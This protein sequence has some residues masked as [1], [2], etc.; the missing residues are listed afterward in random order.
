MSLAPGMKLGPYEILSPL[1]AGGM[2]EVWKAKD[3]RLDRLVAI[4][5]LPE[6]LATHPD[7][8]ARFEREAKAVAALNHPNITALF[9]IGQEGSTAFAVMELLEGESLRSRLT[10]GPQPTRKVLDWARQIAAG[11]AAAHEKGIVH[12]DLKPDNLWITRDGRLK[13]LDFGLAKIAEAALLSSDP[14]QPTRAL[15]SGPRTQ[16]GVVLGT[17]GY[18][19][20]EQIRGQAV[21][22]RSDIFA[23]G[24][25]LFEMLAGQHPFQG[26]SAIETLNAILT[27]E[28]PT[29]DPTLEVPPA[30]ARILDHCLQ[31]DPAN[32][33]QSAGD[34]AFALETLSQS[35][36]SG[37]Y[38]PRPGTS[39]TTRTRPAGWTLGLALAGLLLGLAGL[40]GLALK[41]GL[42]EEPTHRQL[43][44]RQGTLLAA[45]FHPD[46]RNLLLTAAWDGQPLSLYRMGLDGTPATDL[47]IRHARIQAVNA[48]GEALLVLLPEP[49]WSS[50]VSDFRTSEGTLALLSPDGGAP[51]PLLK[52]VHAADFGPGGQELAVAY[53]PAE[54]PSIRVEYP[55]GMVLHEERGGEIWELRCSPD[56]TRVAVLRAPNEKD[57]HAILVLDRKGRRVEGWTD[58]CRGPVWGLAWSADGEEL[59]FHREGA[60]WAVNRK[61]RERILRREAVK[62]EVMD[63]SRS[64]ACLVA[65]SILQASTFVRR[66]GREIDLSS[67]P[68]SRMNGITSDGRQVLLNLAGGQPGVR[69][70]LRPSSGGPQVIL[71]SG[72]ALDLHPGGAWVFVNDRS[73][74]SERFLL[75]P[76]GPGTPRVVEHKGFRIWGGFF[77]ASGRNLMV[78]A[79]GEGRGQEMWR[80]P[81]EGGAWERV[82]TD[83]TGFTTFTNPDDSAIL[84]LGADHQPTLKSLTGGASRPL[85]P[86][87]APDQAIY[88]W[89]GQQ[90][91]LV[92]PDLLGRDM[93]IDLL[94]LRTG[95][96]SPWQRI[97][98]SDTSG[99]TRVWG[100]MGSR[101]LST[102]VYA[103]D[104]QVTSDL[105]LLEGLK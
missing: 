11:L 50:G 70:A 93:P 69:P 37:G 1:G 42:R 74:A 12:R 90:R 47:G 97:T 48:R 19:S 36:Y 71:G 17:V 85:G 81:L 43:T 39:S 24:V 18:M 98:V 14:D 38:E 76:C 10:Q 80:V 95:K 57:P 32:R 45:R 5:V 103:L 92:G 61:G 34:L 68:V 30:A 82:L 78:L 55:R 62:L 35:S 8:L 53:H 41:P 88:G 86:P 87:L 22:A 96:R 104:R 25:V 72:R 20:P 33:F 60:L 15:E 27:R 91:L 56:G 26:T 54:A 79:T 44:A 29:L 84:C 13:I 23:L 3:T 77:G 52:E 100:L 6:H 28:P 102:L 63:V 51:H 9:D 105:F 94:D 40:T 2:G 66:D 64:G 75:L 21:D 73:G 89:D 58:S 31:K 49:T 65:R 7:A 83:T 4:K 101:D 59:W 67:A 99:S 46:G 16:E